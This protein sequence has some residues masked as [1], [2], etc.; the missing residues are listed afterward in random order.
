MELHQ[1]EYFL[2]VE[3]YGSF[4]AASQ[5]I[6]VSQSTLSQQI[7]KLEE[8]LGVQ[9]FI[10]HPRSI[11]LTLPDG[12]FLFM[13]CASNKKFNIHWKPSKNTPIMKKAPLS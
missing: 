11:T 9:L 5:E 3:K 6:N 12:I 10:R 13:W 8:E 1:L 7:K 4:S 2:A